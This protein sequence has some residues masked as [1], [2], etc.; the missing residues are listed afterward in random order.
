[1]SWKKVLRIAVELWLILRKKD[2]EPAA[3]QR[4]PRLE[5]HTRDVSASPRAIQPPAGRNGRTQGRP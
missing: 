3:T 4:S 2:D 5:S 1:M